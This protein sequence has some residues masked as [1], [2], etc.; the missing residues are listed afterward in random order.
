M[1]D[2][3][4]TQL[5]QIKQDETREAKLDT[6]KGYESKTGDATACTDTDSET[7][8]SDHNKTDMIQREHKDRDN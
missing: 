3:R 4:K 5:G 2:R 7:R 6:N 8:T 1:G